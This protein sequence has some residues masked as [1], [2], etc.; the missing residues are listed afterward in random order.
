[1]SRIYVTK[2][3]SD[4]ETIKDYWLG[5]KDVTVKELIDVQNING[6]E[7]Y[8]LITG[9]S[10]FRKFEEAMFRKCVIILAI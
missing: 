6:S 7:R 10:G 2:Y 3:V 1:M 8:V 5:N 9:A 4:V